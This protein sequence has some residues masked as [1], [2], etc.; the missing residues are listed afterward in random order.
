MNSVKGP[1]DQGL[2]RESI[3]KTRDEKKDASTSSIISRANTSERREEAKNSDASSSLST[4]IVTNAALQITVFIMKVG[5]K[6][7][8]QITSQEYVSHILTRS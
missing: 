6:G 4:L 1:E 8:P 7:A 2:S 3:E 5:F